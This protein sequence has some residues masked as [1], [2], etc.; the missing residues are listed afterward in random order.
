MPAHRFLRCRLSPAEEFSKEPCRKRNAF[1]HGVDEVVCICLKKA[2]HDVIGMIRIE[3]DINCPKG[4][5]LP[6]IGRCWYIERDHALGASREAKSNVTTGYRWGL[7]SF[8]EG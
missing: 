7:S 4:V 8:T 6:V 3:L 1:L 5:S 2:D